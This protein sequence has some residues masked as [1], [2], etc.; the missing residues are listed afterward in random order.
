D[1]REGAS[2]R[3]LAE[4]KR[5]WIATTD[6]WLTK[7]GQ[8]LRQS[9]AVGVINRFVGER[10][11][12]I[13]AAGSLPGD[14]QKLWRDRTADGNGYTCEYGYSAMGFE[15][16][17]GLGARLACPEREVV[18]LVGDLSFLMSS[19]ELVTAVEQRIAYTVVV[20]DNHGGQS[21]RSLQRGR[22]FAD[23]AM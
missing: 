9:T 23:F 15:I 20:F 5:S 4:A 6:A 14:L 11:T 16:A 21:I 19:Q 2:A 7:A 22:G 10:S 1:R 3:E 8:P 12:V 18:V 17:G 13:S